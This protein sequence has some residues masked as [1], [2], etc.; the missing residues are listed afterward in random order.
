M[1]GAPPLRGAL[2][3]RDKVAGFE[4]ELTEF[5]DKTIKIANRNEFYPKIHKPFRPQCIFDVWQP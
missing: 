3:K 1:E 5:G 2:H 4:D